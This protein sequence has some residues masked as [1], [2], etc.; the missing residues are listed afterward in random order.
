MI[1]KSMSQCVVVLGSVMGLMG[2][3]SA[4]TEQET[5]EEGSAGEGEHAI[6]YQGEFENGLELKV[7]ELEEGKL[8][9]QVSGSTLDGS[10]DEASAALRAGST[11]ELIA[12]VSGSDELP[13]ELEAV[14]TELDAVLEAD[15]W[16]DNDADDSIVEKSES[17]FM[18]TVC[19]TLY[20]TGYGY[21]YAESC[22]FASSTTR[23]CTASVYNASDFSFGWNENDFT[24]NWSLAGSSWEPSLSAYRWSWVRY[25]NSGASG[26]SICLEAPEIYTPG[27][28]VQL[29]GALGVTVH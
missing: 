25:G 4:S 22:K 24:A 12:A 17:S 9:Y 15:S 1:R 23:I 21:K 5:G 7:V 2:C 20:V 14:E 6:V 28:W 26:A 29:Y 18:S 8:A 3:G 11:R 10:V 16:K 13:E 27:G 19:K